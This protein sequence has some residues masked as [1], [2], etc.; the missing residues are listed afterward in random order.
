[1]RLARLLPNISSWV[2][3]LPL[4]SRLQKLNILQNSKHQN[5]ALGDALDEALKNKILMEIKKI[6]M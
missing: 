2:M 5:D 6:R 1:M 3:T 4:R